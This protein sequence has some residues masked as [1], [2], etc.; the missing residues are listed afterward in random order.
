MIPPSLAAFCTLASPNAN[1]PNTLVAV[2]SPFL[3][4]KGF[5]VTED[6]NTAEYAT[7]EKIGQL[8]TDSLCLVVKEANPRLAF[9]YLYSKVIKERVYALK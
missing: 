4:P 1:Q 2:A 6:G 7:K 8:T 3:D 9:L 5:E